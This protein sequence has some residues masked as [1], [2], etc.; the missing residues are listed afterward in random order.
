M[1]RYSQHSLGHALQS[2]LKQLELSRP[3][4][5]RPQE[6]CVPFFG[7]PFH[8]SFLELLACREAQET[9]DHQVVKWT[10]SQRG[11]QSKIQLV[12]CHF[13]QQQEHPLVHGANVS[14]VVLIGSQ[15]CQG[16]IIECPLILSTLSG[17]P[18]Y[19]VRYRVCA[20]VSRYMVSPSKRA[21]RTSRVA[22]SQGC[23]HVLA[24]LNTAAICSILLSSKELNVGLPHA[25]KGRGCINPN[26]I[27]SGGSYP[28]RNQRIHSHRVR[29]MSLPGTM[30]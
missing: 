15:F 23:T 11:K 13:A 3:T 27:V 17:G 9:R 25:R 5:F 6:S 4:G 2:S 29:F 30:Q 18:I 21:T 7:V 14:I 12:P 16:A 10:L 1:S 26:R 28:S 22:G 19:P 24:K 20:R 8:P